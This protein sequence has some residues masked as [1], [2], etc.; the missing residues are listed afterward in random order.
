MP[1]AQTSASARGH[2]STR[3]ST[4]N[5]AI[6]KLY[7]ATA[8]ETFER[9]LPRI[10]RCLGEL[11]QQQIWWRPN[12][13][14]NSAGNLTLHLCG[15]IRQWIISGLGGAHDLRVRDAE[16]AER[17]PLPRRF[18]VRRLQQTVREALG[19]LR[20]LPPAVL[21][22]RYRIQGFQV[23]GLRAVFNVAE[24][25]SYHAGQIIYIT[26]MKRARNLRFTKLPASSRRLDHI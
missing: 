4:G 1:R 24:H 20:C 5:T 25:F 23:T 6:A 16:F 18:L 14:S 17:G 7:L 22:R 10:V 8:E 11:S 19:V 26:K 21:T 3:I 2:A 13:A 15:N 9:Y 12:P